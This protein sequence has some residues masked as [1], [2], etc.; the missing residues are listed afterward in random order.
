MAK[1]VY[2]LGAGINMALSDSSYNPETDSWGNHFPPLDNSFF[3][4]ALKFPKYSDTYYK[5]YY[6]DRKIGPPHKPLFDYISKYWKL[7]REDLK[8][9]S[10]SLEACYT[11]IQL[12]RSEALKDFYEAADDSAKQQDALERLKELR[13]V[14]DALT[15]FLADYLSQFHGSFSSAQ[16][17]FPTPLQKFGAIVLVEGAAVL[18]FN[19][20]SLLEQAIQTVSGR[21]KWER[22]SEEAMDEIWTTGRS[23]S[24]EEWKEI[25]TSR[26]YHWYLPL[27]YGVEFDLVDIPDR[28]EFRGSI[29]KELFYS[30]P[31]N[32]LYKA[33]FLKLHGSFNWI[34]YV[35]TPS[36][37]TNQEY[38]EVKDGQVELKSSSYTGGELYEEW[39]YSGTEVVFRRKLLIVP[40]VLYK[41]IYDRPFLRKIWQRARQELEECERLIIGGY[42]FPPTDFHTQK[43]FL[44]AFTE[45]TPKEIIVIN[46]DQNPLIAQRI[47]E[48]CH[49]E[50]PVCVCKDLEEYITSHPEIDIDSYLS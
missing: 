39:N 50:K 24:E 36:T 41:N 42:S 10:L 20:D 21:T 7:S 25:V 33:P 18:T 14:E 32:N 47:K 27:A 40:P 11:L 26:D 31:E 49:F 43:L 23:F 9:E 44:E 48:L 19:Y 17:S 34:E 15:S 6:R 1:T 37:S 35:R 2:M 38:P 8:V 4:E 45:H 28:L 13:K 46:P 16:Q 3:R 5:N 22:L 30:H 12:Q 29:S